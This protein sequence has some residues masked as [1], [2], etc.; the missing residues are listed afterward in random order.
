M[1]K[2]HVLQVQR[3][4]EPGESWLPV[5]VDRLRERYDQGTITWEQWVMP[6][7]TRVYFY[8][9]IVISKEG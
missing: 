5:R 4:A 9:T 8:N 2:H 1:R 3:G 7:G 6:D